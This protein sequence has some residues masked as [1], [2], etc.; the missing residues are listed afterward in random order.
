MATPYCLFSVIRGIGD[1]SNQLTVGYWTNKIRSQKAIKISLKPTN[2]FLSTSY[3]AYKLCKIIIFMCWDLLKTNLPQPRITWEESLRLG[4]ISIILICENIRGEFSCLI[5]DTVYC[6]Q[7][8]SLAWALDSMFLT[9][10]SYHCHCF[11]GKLTLECLCL[12]SWMQ[13][14]SVHS[15][16]DFSEMKDH[17]VQPW[18]KRNPPWCLCLSCLSR[19]TEWD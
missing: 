5:I 14:S 10:K 15:Y 11:K 12:C 16:L 2:S 6:R 7:H 9:C 4:M 13:M 19:A 18:A 3:P 8:C 1:I 17:N